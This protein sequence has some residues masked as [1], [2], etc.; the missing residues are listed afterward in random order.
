MEFLPRQKACYKTRIKHV[1]CSLALLVLLSSAEV[2]KSSD[3]PTHVGDSETLR[4]SANCFNKIAILQ[5]CDPKIQKFSIAQ[6][7]IPFPMV[8]R[9][10]RCWVRTM[11]LA[12]FAILLQHLQGSDSPVGLRN[13]APESWVC[14]W[15]HW[16]SGICGAAIFSPDARITSL[17]H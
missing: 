5:G 7:M 6:H 14:R 13:W 1:R 2:K 12:G 9:I 3:S 16:P 4:E 10:I 17:R 11:K 15:V 8:L